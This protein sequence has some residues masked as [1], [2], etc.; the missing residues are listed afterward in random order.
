MRRYETIFIT[1][2]DIIDEDRKLFFEKVKSSINKH[3]GIL[4][5][6]DE[7]GVKKLAYEIK[8]KSRGYYVRIDYCGIDSLVN[9]LERFFR[10]DECVL[11]FITVLLNK[12]IDI[13]SIK[14]EIVKKDDGEKKEEIADSKTLKAEKMEGK[15]EKMEGEE[16]ETKSDIEE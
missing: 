5:E 1:D 8:K 12:D 7:W 14:E 4:I 16:T 3:E 13:A 6:F 10:I 9:E 15:A 11:K 2:T